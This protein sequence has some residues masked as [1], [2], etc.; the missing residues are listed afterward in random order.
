M[1]LENVSCSASSENHKYFTFKLVIAEIQLAQ[2]DENSQLP[3]EETC[4][5]IESYH[6]S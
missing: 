6:S 2:L 4:K 1:F 3:G 5:H